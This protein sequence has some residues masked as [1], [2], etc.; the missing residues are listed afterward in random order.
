MED[1]TRSSIGMSKEQLKAMLDDEELLD[2][3]VELI[4]KLVKKLEEKGYTTDQAIKLAT[5]SQS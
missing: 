3:Q 4:D 5:S 2:L 1:A